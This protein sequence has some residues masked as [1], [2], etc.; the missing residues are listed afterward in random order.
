VDQLREMTAQAGILV[1]LAKLVPPEIIDI[2]P[3]GL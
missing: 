2:F 1:A 3:T